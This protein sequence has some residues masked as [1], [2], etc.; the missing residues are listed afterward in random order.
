MSIKKQIQALFGGADTR[1]SSVISL[2]LVNL[3]PVYG[4]LFAGWDIFL[5]MFV[6]WAENVVIGFY[7][8]LRMLA[9]KPEEGL[10]W[11]MK[12][13]MIPFFILHYGVFTSAHG[14]FVVALFGK[15]LIEHS[16]GP[17]PAFFFSIIRNF[18]LSWV[19]AALFASHGYSF[20]TNFI[21]RDE[22]KKTSPGDLMMRPYSR[23]FLL[24]IT[25]IVGGII[26]MAL[27]SAI[28]GLL[29]FILLKIAMDLAAHV[30]EHRRYS[31]GKA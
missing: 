8:I 29:L 7:N 9:C 19:I 1:F 18:H 4:V 20:V 24:H 16:N 17:S 21:M 23:V 30:K 10:V 2:I 15:S 25:L 31:I 12:L 3:I 27:H 22:Y 14:I 6:F 13:F 5:I 28:Y 11:A 26:M